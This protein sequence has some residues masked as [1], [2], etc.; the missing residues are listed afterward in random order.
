M[1]KGITWTRRRPW[2]WHTFRLK[3]NSKLKNARPWWYVWILIVKKSTSIY[4]RLP[5]TEYLSLYPSFYLSMH[6][7][8]LA[9]VYVCMRVYCIVFWGVLIIQQ[10]YFTVVNKDLEVSPS[11][12]GQCEYKVLRRSKPTRTDD[13]EENY[14]YVERPEKQKTRK[15]SFLATIDL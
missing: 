6:T 7:H 14:L 3:K 13:E 2:G 15:H 12:A 11:F 9:C 5:V 10:Y 8:V 4:D 1:K